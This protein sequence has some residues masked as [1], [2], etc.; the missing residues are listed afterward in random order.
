MSMF[1]EKKI[2]CNCFREIANETFLSKPQETEPFKKYL[3]I[4]GNKQT[5]T[6]K[7]IIINKRN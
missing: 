3:F 4:F 5:T 7:I 6:T 2:V 1:P